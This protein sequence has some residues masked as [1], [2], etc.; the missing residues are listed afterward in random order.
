MAE[1]V[2]IGIGSNLG[3]KL[4]NCTTAIKRIDSID[5]CSVVECS[6]FYRTDPVGVENQDWFVNAVISLKAELTPHELL[7]RLL[8]IE[9]DMGRIRRKK[10]DA[11]VIDLDILLFGDR[12][13]S[14]EDLI[15]PHPRLHLRRFVL[16]PLVDIAPNL[17]HPLLALSMKE[18]LEKCSDMGQGVYLMEGT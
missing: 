11:R 1:I 18:L 16:V 8:S 5:R 3:E 6:P 2:Y 12:V 17:V 4:D 13:I 15:V 14:E 7:N 9:E 10:W